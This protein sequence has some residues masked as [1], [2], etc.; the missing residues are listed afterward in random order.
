MHTRA[1]VLGTSAAWPIPRPGCGCPQCVE[2]R[3]DPRL[4]RTRTCLRLEAGRGVFVFD[5]GPDVLHQL[6]R[7][8]LSPR[9]DAVLVS[10]AHHDHLLGLSDLVRLQPD[11]APPLAVHAAPEHQQRIRAV[12]P[13]L[14]RGGRERIVLRRFGDGM[15]LGLG[16]LYFEGIETGHR[17]GFSTTALL[18]ETGEGDARRRI[19]YATDMGE[20]PAT[21]RTRLEGIDLLVGDGTWL[22][23]AGHGHPGTD[24]VVA[25]G[26]ELGVGRVAI[27]HVGHWQVPEAT[28]RGRL[29]DETLLLRDGE[30]LLTR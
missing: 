27:T 22:G 18:L 26:A 3:G 24:D 28:A 15:R 23:Q 7:E 12:F 14:L 4:R 29:G 10:H 25:L 19:L 21:S 5:P 11:E 9:A 13:D 1:L 17:A 16:S 30:D 8:G 20:L 6:E 2:A